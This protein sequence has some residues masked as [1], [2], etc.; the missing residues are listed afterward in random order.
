MAHVVSIKRSMSSPRVN[1]VSVPRQYA[2][3]WALEN[4]SRV[5]RIIVLN[6]PL[7]TG[8]KMPFELQQY[9][10]PFVSSFVA[11]VRLTYMQQPFCGRL[12]VLS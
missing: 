11:Q 9:K 1:L 6:T 3:E 5:Q 4:P 8:S 2:M 7:Q 12:K 10:L